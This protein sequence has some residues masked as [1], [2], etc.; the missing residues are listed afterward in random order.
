MAQDGT[1]SSANITHDTAL[2]QF[3]PPP[4]RPISIE[5][6]SSGQPEFAPPP[7]Q[8]EP[9]NGKN[10]EPQPCYGKYSV[11]T[12]VTEH[13]PGFFNNVKRNFSVTSLISDLGLKPPSE[14]DPAW[15]PRFFQPLPLMGLAAL[16]G[17]VCCLFASLGI[18]VGSQG[19]AV[20]SWPWP[21]SVFLAIFSAVVNKLMTYALL[22]ALPIAWWHQAYQG[23]TLAQLHRYADAIPEILALV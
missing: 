5:E 3:S 12:L 11:T 7:R 15:R 20:D 16:F 18:L 10:G 22:Q 17:T 9:L 2:P 21:P 13:K 6:S 23:A 14:R 1:R 19:Q 8:D 4:T